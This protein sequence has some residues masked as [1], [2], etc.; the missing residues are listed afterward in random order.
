MT[1]IINFHY[2]P[3]YDG[4]SRIGHK[5]HDKKIIKL[6]TNIQTKKKLFFYNYLQ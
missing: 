2:L 5:Y 6:N 4:V 3:I 1:I